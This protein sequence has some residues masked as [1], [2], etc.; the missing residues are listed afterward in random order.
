MSTYEVSVTGTY[1]LGF[2]VFNLDDTAL[3]PVLMVDSELGT[4]QICSQN[5]SCETFGG[6]EANNDTAPTLPPTTT[7]E[8]APTTTTTT[9]PPATSLE[10]TSLDDTT[11]AG[12]LRWAITQAN[13]Q[14][15]GI[16]DS[17]TF[18]SGLEGTITLTSDLPAITQS[19]SITGNGITSTIIDG[20]NLY[21]PIYNNGQ[22]TV[23]LSNMTLKNGKVA[24]GGLAW[25]NQGTFTVTSVKFSNT[26]QYAWYQQNQT[27]TTFNSCIFANNYAGIR[28]DYGSTPT[29]KSLTD[30]DYQNRIYVNNSQF[31][32]NNYGLA[33]ERFVRIN[34]SVFT[35]N[36][37][38]GAQLQG[39]NRQQV[40]NSTFTNNGTAVSLFSYIPTGWTPG[41]D[42]QLVEGN[43]FTENG[44]AINVN[45]YFN[46]GTK[47]YN[48]VYANSWST[49]RNNTFDNNSTI[50]AGS[51][52][53]V[54]NNTVVT[55]TTTTTSS[56]T[57]TTTTTTEPAVVPPPVETIP[58]E[59]TTVSIP[60]LETVISPTTTTLIQTIFDPVEVTPV[61]TP[62][63]ESYPE[64]DGP[65]ASVPQYAPEQET[66]TQT[67][68]PPL[69]VPTETQDAADAAVADIFDGPMS[70][71]GLANAV[72]DLVA[73]AETPEALSAVVNSLLDQELTDTQFSTV[74]DSVFDGPMSDENFSAAV[75]AVFADTSTLSDEQF[76]T[77]VQAVF[78]GPLSTEQFGDALEAVF[79]EPLSDEKF[80]AIID[81]VLDE[82]L[83]DE[84]FAEV[85]GILE[86]DAVSEEQVAAAV[87]SILENEVSA[88]QATDLATSEKVLESIDADQ[89]AEIF[90]AVEVDNL[91][92]A[93]EA[94]LVAAVT[95]APDE[96]KN[97][98]EET[99]DIFAEGLDEYVALGSQVDV[100]TR[101][102]LIAASAAVSTL[103]A[104]GAA[105][106]ASGGSSGPSSGGNGGNGGGNGNAEG[107][108]KKQ[109]E[110]EQEA[111]GEIAGPEEDEDKKHFTRNSIFKYQEN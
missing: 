109:E 32:N 85:V 53:V 28:S 83:S 9:L 46:N 107:R 41:T 57:T 94:A 70:N 23:A 98:F 44:I 102:S 10:V 90:D 65:A 95:D 68:E 33:T 35:N 84:Q 27:V 87:D 93:E 31:L 43:T 75:D 11:S 3:S 74:I 14:S 25:T 24:T 99:I 76:D 79:S 103:T 49:S 30:S 58:T 72:D 59:N 111:S 89:A 2:T 42:N 96:V 77:A 56:T 22:R 101:R 39:L 21:R 104:A 62:P 4:T 108:G 106:A 5:G 80:D 82:P 81:A 110:G 66:T 17:I 50:Y 67:D 20:N 38:A 18:Q 48:D 69:V 15:G 6:V 97:A 45:N 63:S 29:T 8:P 51:D 36:S 37:I 64:G 13:A 91:T 52:F 12:T 54:E 86:S 40:Y 47:I 19:V 34:N 16:Y 78:D 73:D 26:Q 55:T 1:K 105:G 7:T 71:A 100:G 61:E 60:E 92:P 88:E